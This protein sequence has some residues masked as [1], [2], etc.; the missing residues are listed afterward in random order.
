MRASVRRAGG[1]GDGR[2]GNG[3]GG[4]A[5]RVAA[6]GVLAG[7][8]VAAVTLLGGPAGAQV[9]YPDGGTPPTPVT[10]PS[11]RPPA[12]TPRQ[13]LPITGGDVAGLAALGLVGTVG[14]A[15]LIRRSRARRPSGD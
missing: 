4:G 15:V 1:R 10:G 8:A 6:R 12:P 14:G 9:H 5:R 2:D 7:L 11:P 3:R 13:S